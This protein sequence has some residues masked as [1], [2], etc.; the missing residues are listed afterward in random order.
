MMAELVDG[1]LSAGD[2]VTVAVTV[3]VAAAGLI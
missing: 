2:V 3:A 1:A